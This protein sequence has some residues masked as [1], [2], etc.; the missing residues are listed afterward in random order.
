MVPGAR[1]P[2]SERVRPLI[3]VTFETTAS[4]FLE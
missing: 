3:V 4:T 1:K 2:E